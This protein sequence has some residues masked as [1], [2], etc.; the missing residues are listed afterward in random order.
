MY[1]AKSPFMISFELCVLTLYL[2]NEYFFEKPPLYFWGE[3]LSFGMFGKITEFTARFPV[4]LYGTL[5]GFLTYFVGKKISKTVFT[6]I[7]VKFFV[8]FRKVY[9]RFGIGFEYIAPD[10]ACHNRA[11]N[12]DPLIGASYRYAKR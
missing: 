1:F 11:G 10:F 4:A 6:Y 8:E 9:F 3:C 5:C 2:N 7:D 12:I